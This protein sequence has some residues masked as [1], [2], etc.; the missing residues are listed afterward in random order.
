MTNRLIW[1]STINPFETLDVATWLVTSRELSHRGI[2]VTLIGFGPKGRHRVH[3]TEITCFPWPKTYFLGQALYHL[4]VLGFLAQHLTTTDLVY[5]HQI[6]ALW[7]IPLILWCRCQGRDVPLFVM[8]TRD[9][10]DISSG[11]IKARMRM[12]YYRLIYLLAPYIFDGQTAITPEMARLV[13]IPQKHLWGTWPSGVELDKFKDAVELRLWPKTNEPIHLM[14]IGILL[15]KRNPAPLCRAVI[16]ANQEG[17]QFDLTFVGDGPERDT[18]QALAAQS[19]GHICIQ[20]PVAHN[21]IP[22]L[23]EKAHV[24]VTSLPNVNDVKYEASSPIKIFE[25]LA[26]GMPI[27]ASANPCHTQVVAQNNYAFWIEQVDEDTIVQTLREIWR[28]RNTLAA[29]G[30]AALKDAEKW[31]WKS[32][33]EKLSDSLQFGLRLKGANIRQPLDDQITLS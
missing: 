30:Q 1:I 2:D 27:L 5:F 4:R 22:S 7:M 3:E 21:E 28:K 24:G 6:S 16:R 31:S 8:D 13:K 23:L 26:A 32:A 10:M 29:L 25:Y 12:T 17:M 20:E 9:L 33:S 15:E 19:N 14:Y 11:S 18:L